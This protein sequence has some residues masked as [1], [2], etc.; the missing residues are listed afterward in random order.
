M[1]A[2]ADPAARLRVLF[3]RT[4]LV[5]AALT[6][7]VVVASA[8][9]RHTQVGLACADWPACY[10]RIDSGAAADAAPG[11]RIVRLA[12]RIAATTVLALVIGLVLIAWTQRPAWRKEGALATAALALV[13]GL[14]IL[15]VATPG[16]RVPAVTL[17]NLLGGF[18]L[19]ALLA[20]TA[21]AARADRTAG[22]AGD[23]LPAALALGVFAL[24][25]LQAVL[26]G[27]IGAQYALTACTTGAKCPALPSAGF[28]AT[29]ALDPFR[30][31]TVVDGRVVAPLDAGA[32]VVIHRALAIVVVAVALALAWRL[33][34]A[35]R[36]LA[37]TLA[38]LAVTAALAGVAAMSLAPSLA[39]TVVH[40]ACSALLVATLAVAA[41]SAQSAP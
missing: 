41:A 13:A 21:A 12:H 39:L 24:V 40:N 9:M 1:T 15:G 19:L 35:S 14:A 5:A 26:G 7:V 30:P 34:T 18:L 3:A 29:A 6:L 36:R 38:I 27:S 11:V 28:A 22:R 20:A 2:A 33:R 37:A 31:L 17:G 10:G 8:F 32:L 23:A 25:L 4:A 16:A